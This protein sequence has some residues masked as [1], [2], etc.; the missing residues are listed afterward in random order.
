MIH[1]CVVWRKC[2]W[3]VTSS[4]TVTFEERLDLH[5]D[6]TLKEYYEN[7]KDREILKYPNEGM[8]EAVKC[9][10]PF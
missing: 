10:K 1:L 7:W 2:K 3:V 9:S 4:D 5:D 8:K 6:G